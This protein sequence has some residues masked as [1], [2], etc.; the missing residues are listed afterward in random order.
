MRAGGLLQPRVPHQGFQGRPHQVPPRRELV[1]GA[2]AAVRAVACLTDAQTRRVNATNRLC[3]PRATA[4]PHLVLFDINNRIF[5]PYLAAIHGSGTRTW[6]RR[7]S[8]LSL[9]AGAVPS[10]TATGTQ[11]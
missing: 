2:A 7:R 4:A 1:P 10:T 9:A 8:S 6:S 5:G 3:W 11:P